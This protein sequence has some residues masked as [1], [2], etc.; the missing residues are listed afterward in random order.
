MF[1]SLCNPRVPVPSPVTLFKNHLDPPLEHLSDTVN[2]LASSLVAFRF[3]S[4][5]FC[6][7]LQCL[8]LLSLI[9]RS[10]ICMKY[11]APSDI[12]DDPVLSEVPCVRVFQNTC[13]MILNNPLSRA[14]CFR[15]HHLHM[16]PSSS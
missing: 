14:V 10:G 6:S 5:G 4:I 11:R 2:K 3:Q 12:D 1:Y 13:I 9:R 16:L 15:P 7:A 8:W